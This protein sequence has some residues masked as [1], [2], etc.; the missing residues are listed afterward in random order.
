MMVTVYDVHIQLDEHAN[1]TDMV[2]LRDHFKA[3]SITVVGLN[4]NDFKAKSNDLTFS[5]YGNLGPFMMKRMVQEC[6]QN[7]FPGSIVGLSEGS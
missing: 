3:L 6:A 2:K 7:I 4:I 5:I 1:I